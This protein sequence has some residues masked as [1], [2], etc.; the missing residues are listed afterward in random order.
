MVKKK[1]VKEFIKDLAERVICT[2][3]ESLLGT[4]GATATFGEVNWGLAFSVA[5][6]ASLV[7]VLK[8]IVAIKTGEKVSASLV[9]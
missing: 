6:L 8:C 7:S 9:D 5:G 4:I 3:A 1:T 2:F